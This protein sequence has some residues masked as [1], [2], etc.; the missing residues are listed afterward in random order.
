MDSPLVHRSQAFMFDSF[1]HNFKI[2]I[3][4]VWSIS[5]N[6]TGC[7][8]IAEQQK[9]KKQGRD[10]SIEQFSVF[11]MYWHMHAQ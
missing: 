3:G 2:T 8:G 7:V 1:I 4:V 5:L 9:V 10:L 6:L 11:Y